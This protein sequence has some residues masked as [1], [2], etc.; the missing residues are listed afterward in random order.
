MRSTA[1]IVA[2]VALLVGAAPAVAK[3]PSPSTPGKRKLPP[4]KRW[5]R[6]SVT[7][8]YHEGPEGEAPERGE[9]NEHNSR[10]SADSRT[11]F[12]LSAEQL[13]WPPAGGGK[14]ITGYDFAAGMSGQLLSSDST[15]TTYE[16]SCTPMVRR[17]KQTVPVPVQ[18]IIRG[19]LTSDGVQASFD[20]DEVRARL[21]APPAVENV[22]LSWAEGFQCTNESGYVYRVGIPLPPRPGTWASTQPCG[23]GPEMENM[24]FEVKGR[25][26]FGRT[27]SLTAICGAW[28]YE[29]GNPAGRI[30]QRRSIVYR[31][32]FTPC[33][34]GGLTTKGC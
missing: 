11:A 9:T 12:I 18:G 16:P 14:T 20:A 7:T 29:N 30:L 2:A 34:N 6:L 31:A 5:Y 13:T 28:W 3:R 10:W 23:Y 19:F 8:Q 4:T 25:V 24:S 27:F 17:S 1:M 33:P 26:R 21:A 15:T 22:S 32:T